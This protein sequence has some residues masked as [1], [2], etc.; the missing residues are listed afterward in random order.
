MVG[1]GERSAQVG[2]KRY[3]IVRVV[4]VLF[5]ILCR[6]RLGS[7]FRSFPLWCLSI[8]KESKSTFHRIH[9]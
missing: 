8:A 9:R 5:H 1:G 4:E 2:R 7:R 3:R 6:I